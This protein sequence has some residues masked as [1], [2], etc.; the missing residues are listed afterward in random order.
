MREPNVIEKEYFD[1]T[2]RGRRPSWLH[3]A[4]PSPAW[5]RR[6]FPHR[7]WEEWWIANEGILRLWRQFLEKMMYKWINKEVSEFWGLHTNSRVNNFQSSEFFKDF[8]AYSRKSGTKHCPYILRSWRIVQESLNLKRAS[9]FHELKEWSD[10]T[11]QGVEGRALVIKGRIF[12]VGLKLPRIQK[13][14]KGGNTRNI[15]H[16]KIFEV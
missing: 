16:W 4:Y 14:S 8:F 3:G 11:S 2:K 1:R 6:P 7:D 15:R 10:R 9:R 12:I 5:D 13:L